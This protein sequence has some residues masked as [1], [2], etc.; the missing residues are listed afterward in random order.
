MEEAEPPS[1][2]SKKTG[3]AIGLLEQ[4]LA[5]DLEEIILTPNPELNE[6]AVLNPSLSPFPA[7]GKIP[8]IY[9]AEIACDP[10]KGRK[11]QDLTAFDRR[12]VIKHKSLKNPL[13]L[14][15]ED[16]III[17]T[18]EHYELFGAEDPRITL[19]DDTYYITYTGFDGWSARICLASTKDFKNIEKHGI[20]GPNMGFEKAISLVGED[21]YKKMWAEDFEKGKEKLKQ[22]KGFEQEVLRVS[23]KDAILHYNEEKQEW[24]LYHRFD[25]WAQIAVAKNISD[26]QTPEFWEEQLINIDAHTKM[27]NNGPYFSK[28]V[29]WGSPIFK[30][31]DKQTMVYHGVDEK[32]NYYGTFCEIKNG[33]IVA[34]IQDP[35]LKPT[36][37]DIFVYT[38]EKGKKKTKGVIFPT[39][40]LVDEPND[41]VYV[42]S[43]SKDEVIKVRSTSATWLYEQLNHPANRIAA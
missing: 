33:R 1:S 38:D 10:L 16:N 36:D 25:P 5:H 37:N 6:I 28:K 29:G 17:D 18:D 14:T 7:D 23:N 9:R 22:I 24:Q 21:L 32:L 12:S 4:E 13:E 39:A 34:S 41:R 26:F 11:I 15:S 19:V 20:I 31:G 43:G 42:Y 3:A 8:F 30:L 35:L 40:A 2:N 27:K